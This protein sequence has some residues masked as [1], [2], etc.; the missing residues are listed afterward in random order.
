MFR[1]HGARYR[2]YATGSMM[3]GTASMVL[4]TTVVNVAIPGIMAAFSLSQD[5]A[6]WLS[7]GFLAAMSSTMLMTSW[8]VRRFGQRATYVAALVVFIGAC[9]L[10]GFASRVDLLVVSRILQGA[11]G[12]IITPLSMITIFSVFPVDQRGR[13]MGIYG[14]GVVLAPAIGPAVGGALVEHFGWRAVFFLAVPFCVL[15]LALAPL[16]IVGRAESEQPPPFDWG[17]LAFVVVFIACLLFALNASH[18][19]GWLSASTLGMLAVALMACSAF[20]WWERGRKHPMLDLGVFES[21]QFAAASI[22]ALAY[23]LGLYGTTYLVPLLVQTVVQYSPTKAGALLSPAGLTLAV[24]LPLA[25]LLTD[26]FPARYLITLGLVLFALSSLLF[27][28]ESAATGFWTLAWWLVVGRIG[29]GLIIPALN[30][31][32][33][34]GLSAEHIGHGSSAINFIRQLGGAFGVNI[35]S[36]FLEWRTLVHERTAGLPEAGALASPERIAAF[37]ESFAL[38]AMVFLL[39]TIPAWLMRRHRS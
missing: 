17:G 6:Q 39:A 31:G 24:M 15:G 14:L 37:H 23:G 18:R 5:T 20:V 25:G 28:F 38:V 19:A 9:L 11:A 30:A 2:W 35:L 34:Y 32:A 33:M 8:C 21:P 26:R 4:A 7:T 12:G 16:F 13:A 29:L 27:V 1:K 10:G 22:V 3:L 36:T